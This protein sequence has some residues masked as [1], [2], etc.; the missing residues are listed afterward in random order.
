[1]TQPKRCPTC[2]N[3]LPLARRKCPYCHREVPVDND[4]QS[5]DVMFL[6]EKL[7][8]KFEIISELHHRGSS[9]VY[10]AHDLILDRKVALKTLKFQ[11]DTPAEIIDRWNQNLRRCLRVENPHIARIYAFGSAGALHYIVLEFIAENTLEDIL[12]EAGD[13]QPLWKCLRIGRDIS[14]GLYDAHQIGVVHHRLT[15]SNIVV[16]RD[17]YSRILDLGAA[18]GTIDA[19]A[20][21]PWSFA[22]DSSRYFSPE[23]IE[24]GISEPLSDQ[25][26]IGVILYELLTGQPAY[27]DTGEAGAFARL[28]TDPKPVTEFNPDI[29]EEL[30]AIVMKA[31]SR[32]PEHRFTDCH[33]LALNLESLDPDIWLPDL[34]KS[35]QAP[36]DEAKVALLLAEIKRDEKNREY[37]HA[38][39]LC[40]QALALAP[41]N[42]E[43]T[44]TMLRIQ[45]LHEQE[46]KLLSLIHKALIAFYSNNLSESLKILKQGMNI[47]KNNAELLRLTH[48]I[49]QEQERHRLISALIDAAKIDLAK[50]ALSSAMSQVVRILDIDPGNETAIKLKQRIEF[51]MEDRATLGMLVS[52]AEAAFNSDR[53][54]EAEDIIIKIRKMDPENFHARKLNERIERLK[55]HRLLM[56]LWETLDLEVKKENYRDAISILKHIAQVDPS[57][58]SEIR[59]RLIRMR[60]KITE[61]NEE[62][63]QGE[64]RPLRAVKESDLAQTP[65]E[66]D[67]IA[68]TVDAAEEI[69][70]KTP[71]GLPAATRE[72]LEKTVNGSTVLGQPETPHTSSDQQPDDTPADEPLDTPAAAAEPETDIP[73]AMAAPVESAENGSGKDN[74]E[75]ASGS[76]DALSI[77]PEAVP[78]EREDEQ[79]D[80]FRLTLSGRQLIAIG[81]CILGIVGLLIILLVM[82][83]CGSSI[84]RPEAA[85]PVVVPSITATP[86]AVPTPTVIPS[87][88]V[89]ATAVATG[90]P[91]PIATPTVPDS[92]SASQI[93][94]LISNARRNEQ[95][96]NYEMALAFYREILR[97]D[98]AHPDA[99]RGLENCRQRIEASKR[100]TRQSETPPTGIT[101]TTKPTQPLPTST[102]P[103]EPPTEKPEDIAEVIQVDVKSIQCKPAIPQR[104]RELDILIR[105]SP[106]I[107]TKITHLWLN[108]KRSDDVGYSQIFAV[109]NDSGFMVTI[110]PRDV[111]GTAVIYFLNGLQSD[112]VEFYYGS[113]T[114]PKL[115]P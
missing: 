43:V 101:K 109:R 115:L 1:M 37:Y 88:K 84:A 6:Q 95:G 100:T 15:P 20:Q 103:S 112:G 89:T 42:S 66:D 12:A 77:E 78:F 75:K 11:S 22:M 51:G 7:A 55:K 35:Y 69:L 13:V 114:R 99:L 24:F 74:V 27:E 8:G 81:G 56:N 38:M 46:Q 102:A 110:P 82:H 3:I 63:I 16:S 106:E 76:E 61:T 104:G 72:K 45:Q 113:P 92:G 65:E 85:Q 93:E 108:Y 105:F 91:E 64:T 86:D 29:P 94:R 111:K 68:K 49:M 90:T 19:L 70:E 33:D 107:E 2:L 14:N 26:R 23:Q 62:L 54:D 67:G 98:R 28:E 25:Y 47:D 4:R 73:E 5:L 18:Q 97:I 83:N 10:L 44:T 80:A 58:K 71:A 96:G 48:E 17:G 9:T 79:R 39:A 57:L 60:E 30:N 50:Q 36:T 53:L 59:A 21:K 32:N 31:I 34:E 52:R 40:D 41:Y 87:P